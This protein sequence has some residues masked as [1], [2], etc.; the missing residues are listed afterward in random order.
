MSYRRNISILLLTAM[1]FSGMNFETRFLSS[2]VTLTESTARDLMIKYQP[3][4]YIHSSEK[5]FPAAIEW[6]NLDWSTTT[7]KDSN[8]TITSSYQGPSSYQSN[9][10]IYAS[11]LQNSDG[12]VRLVFFYLFGY[13]GCGPAF[14]AYAKAIGIKISKTVSVCPADVHWSD[15]EGIQIYFNA[16]LSVN[17]L[18][19]DYHSWKTTLTSS[20]VTWEG[21]NPVVYIANGSHAS[22]TTAA[23]Q[24]Y[25]KAWSEKGTGYNTYG[26][27]IDYTDNTGN[28]W[29][30]SNPRLL[31]FNGNPTS[32][33]STDEMN[34]A[35]NYYGHLGQQIENETYN[36]ITSLVNEVA[37]G[38]KVFSKSAYNNIKN[39]ESQMTSLF[40]SQATVAL[41]NPGRTW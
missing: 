21:T 37:D 23:N 38:I 3:V 27:L 13:N 12:T 26:S 2:T 25:D 7:M 19:Y 5:Y 8:A 30:S 1:L 14:E 32:D 11:I 40:D 36:A 29:K 15:L 28:K 16:D 9:A 4:V 10:P 31:K 22:Y 24:E 35:F 39:S 20:Q 41:G 18:V 34:L 33:I 6:F 17:Y